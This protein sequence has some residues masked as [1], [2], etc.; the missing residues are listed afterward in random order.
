MPFSPIMDEPCCHPFPLEQIA[1]L[2][3][4]GLRSWAVTTGS[5]HV[6]APRCA[7]GV[8]KIHLPLSLWAFYSAFSPWGL[9]E[10]HEIR[11]E[12][13]I[14]AQD[15]QTDPFKCGARHPTCWPDFHPRT[16]VVEAEK[17]LSQ[18]VLWLLHVCCVMCLR[19]PTHTNINTNLSKFT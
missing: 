19:T 11:T 6:W 14:K 9:R 3:N 7:N 2:L 18:L 4:P 10:K 8:S 12:L 16:H 15:C 1:G 5:E 13:K 17:R